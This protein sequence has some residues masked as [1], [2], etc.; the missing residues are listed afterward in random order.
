MAETTVTLEP[1][2]QLIH[3]H[4]AESRELRKDVRDVRTL[5]LQTVDSMRKMELR[6]EARMVS[7]LSAVRQAI[8][9]TNC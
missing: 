5:A 9:S 8:E 2:I 3:Q 4:M 7:I 1:I 6:L